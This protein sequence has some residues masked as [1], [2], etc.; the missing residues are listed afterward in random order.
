MLRLIRRVVSLARMLSPFYVPVGLAEACF[1][2]SMNKGGLDIVDS[3]S[4]TVW[5]FICDREQD[6]GVS[7]E[8][9]A[10]MEKLGDKW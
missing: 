4:A 5:S 7:G 9:S 10:E 1:Q 6:P 8:I 3:Y 2:V